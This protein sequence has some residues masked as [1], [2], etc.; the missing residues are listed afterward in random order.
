MKQ[1]IHLSDHADAVNSSTIEIIHVK[2]TTRAVYIKW[3]DP[4][5]P[6]GLILTYEIE[7]MKAN[8]NNVSKHWSNSNLRDWCWDK[9]IGRKIIWPWLDGTFT[10]VSALDLF[11]DSTT[12]DISTSDDLWKHCG[13]KRSYCFFLE[14]SLFPH[15]VFNSVLK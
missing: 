3:K 2:N 4:R 10:S 9:I 1:S 6:N 12:F 14:I 11:H 7:Y 5:M 8:I 13:K 15:N